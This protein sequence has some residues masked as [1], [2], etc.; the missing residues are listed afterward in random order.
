MGRE[1]KDIIMFGRKKPKKLD[2]RIRYQHTD[3]TRKLD[4]AR[5]YKRAVKQS[6]E[7]GG[8]DSYNFLPA[9]GLKTVLAQALAI[10]IAAGLVYL[11]FVP[12]FLSA[13]TI[14]I[15]GASGDDAV[16]VRADVQNYIGGAP[17]YNPRQNLLFLSKSGLSHSLLGDSRIYKVTAIKKSFF[18]RSISVAVELKTQR[19]VVNRNNILYSVYNDGTVQDVITADPAQ[20]L[21][22]NP[23]TIKLK[24]DAPDPLSPG[25]KYLSDQ[26]LGQLDRLIGRFTPVTGQDI[27]YFAV[28]TVIGAAPPPQPLAD[29]TATGS[30][31]IT[32]PP[33]PAT[34][35]ISSLPLQPDEVD[36]LVRK[37]IP[38]YKGSAPDF[39]AMFDTSTDFETVLAKLQLLLSQMTPDRYNRLAYADMR[40][41]N[42][43]FICLVGT[44][45]AV[46]ALPAAPAAGPP[47]LPILPPAQPAPAATPATSP[48]INKKG[49]K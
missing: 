16:Y 26:F 39:K 28:P 35:I 33:Q 24:D 5:H 44:A 29:S 18:H 37:K 6:R 31:L 3:F 19:F 21:G 46:G 8:F 38:N 9:L 41:E 36:V 49:S 22:L 15:Q 2:P 12:N 45:C 10:V 20:W 4:R 7:S 14:N 13:K 30:S 40:F 34:T 25:T 27:D 11:I 42:R 32:Q 47:P 1:L 23:G 48:S 17:F 43:A